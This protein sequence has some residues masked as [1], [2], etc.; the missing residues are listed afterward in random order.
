M[1][2]SSRTIPRE[3]H[4]A[5]HNQQPQQRVQAIKCV[6]FESALL[7]TLPSLFHSPAWSKQHQMAQ[8]DQACSSSLALEYDRLKPDMRF[9]WLA[10]QGGR[11]QNPAMDAKAIRSVNFASHHANQL[12]WYWKMVG[13]G[14]KPR[15]C[16]MQAAKCGK[17]P[18]LAAPSEP[19]LLQSVACSSCKCSQTDKTK[20]HPEKPVVVW[21]T[22]PGTMWASGARIPRYRTG[23]AGHPC[24]SYYEGEEVGSRTIK[25]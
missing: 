2:E 3:T 19:L 7:F 11:T 5:T 24:M 1:R 16:M 10:E 25:L 14:S 23:G 21:C 22:S 15:G 9:T 20:I 4:W 17:K 12:R 13:A 6:D 8:Y 18:A